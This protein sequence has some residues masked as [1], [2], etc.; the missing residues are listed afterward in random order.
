MDVII[1]VGR[2][3]IGERLVRTFSVVEPKVSRQS[4]VRLAQALILPE[5]HLLVFH[6]APQAFDEDVIQRAALAV[7]ADTDLVLLQQA[8]ERLAGKLTALIG[9]EDLRGAVVLDRL[10][11]RLHAERRIHRI[12]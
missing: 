1:D 3:P 5:I 11:Q 9:I 8:G 4:G 12:G 6:R 10:R 7:H 2:R